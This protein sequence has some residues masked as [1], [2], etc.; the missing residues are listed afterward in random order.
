VT[1]THFANAAAFRCWLERHHASSA[2]LLVG[3]YNKAS[4]RGGLTYAEALDEAL[5]FGWIDGVRRRL[6]ADRYTIRFTPRR[7]RSIWSRVNL[8]HVARLRQ[9]GKM[10]AAGLTAFAARTAQKTGV[11]SFENRPEKFPE[12][13]AR[14][15]RSEKAA[16]AFWQKQP[17]GY[18]RTAIWWVISAKQEATRQRRLGQLIADSAA[19]RRLAAIAGNATPRLRARRM[20]R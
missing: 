10:H 4:G 8:R 3:F 20:R 9:L 14:Q 11:Y 6:D 7:P 2:E 18:R 1:P 17:P 13:L 15:F 12:R 16:W 5:C 19:G